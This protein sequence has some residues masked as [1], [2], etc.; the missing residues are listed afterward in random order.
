M[1]LARAT[2]DPN[3]SLPYSIDWTAWLADLTG[4]SIGSAS[5]AIDDPPD[6]SMTLGASGTSGAVATVV[7]NGGTVGET[8]RVRC[9]ITTSPSG[10]IDDRTIAIRVE[11]R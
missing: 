9:R 6:A 10:H 11:E 1:T 8:Y 4:E 2:K 5:W 7:V 3:A